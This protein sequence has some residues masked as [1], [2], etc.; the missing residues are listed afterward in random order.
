MDSDK[1]YAYIRIIKITSTK[2]LNIHERK[3]MTQ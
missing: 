2:K 3:I 1:L